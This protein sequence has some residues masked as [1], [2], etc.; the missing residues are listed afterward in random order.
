MQIVYVYEQ[1]LALNNR[2]WLIY[3][4]SPTNQPSIL[5]SSLDIHHPFHFPLLFLTLFLLFLFL[6][7]PNYLS[8]VVFPCTSFYFYHSI[9]SSNLQFALIFTFFFRVAFI[10]I[11]LLTLAF[12]HSFLSLLSI[13]F[14]SLSRCYNQYPS[15]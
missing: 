9:S 12:L 2:Q 15:V 11:L 14:S 8:F 7:L 4:K 1:D 6:L 3:H 10:S 13:Y 5:Y